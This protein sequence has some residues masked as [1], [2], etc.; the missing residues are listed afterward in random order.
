MA[1]LSGA[2]PNKIKLQSFDCDA[3]C[4]RGT[5]DGRAQKHKSQCNGE[6]EREKRNKAVSGGG[7][8]NGLTV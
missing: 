1:P 6:K 7:D 4:Q 5:E 3:L 8:V 2:L